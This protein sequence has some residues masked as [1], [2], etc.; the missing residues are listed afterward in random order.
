MSM[1]IYC[2]VRI[3]CMNVRE[4]VCVCKHPYAHMHVAN[5][6]LGAGNY[7]TVVKHHYSLIC[8]L[9]PS[10]LLSTTSYTISTTPRTTPPT[11]TPSISSST[12]LQDAAHH[13]TFLSIYPLSF[14]FFFSVCCLFPS[15][16]GAGGLF[17]CSLSN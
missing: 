6:G 4:C 15:T 2:Y 16:R 13:F 14:A 7:C 3:V 17:C 5:T 8:P 11:R 9:A 10:V 12:G 1:C